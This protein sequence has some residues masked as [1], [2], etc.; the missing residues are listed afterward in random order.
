MYCRNL[1]L[2]LLFA[3]NL[4]AQWN[5]Q[6][7]I[8]EA[9]YD[10]MNN[11]EVI[12]DSLLWYAD[13]IS[14]ASQKIGYKAGTGGAIRLRGLYYQLM[15]NF[16]SAMYYYME[17]EQFGIRERV[18]ESQAA[19]LS[20]QY[21]IHLAL[22]QYDE[23]RKKAFQAVDI[24][25]QNGFQRMVAVNYNN[26]GICWRRQKRYDSAIYYYTK[27]L[28]IRRQMND[29]AGIISAYS[30]IGGL[31]L[32]KHRYNEASG[33][34]YPVLDYHKRMKDSGWLWND[35]STLALMY[36]QWKDFPAALAYL[37]T[38][39][40]IA[41]NAQ[42]KMN[43]AETYKTL[44]E[45]LYAKGDWKQAYD[46][47]LLGTSM[48]SELVNSE[49]A[50]RLLE[51]EQKYKSA[52][53]EQQNKL[54]SAEV[55]Q[56]KLQ[57][58]I[59]LLAAGAVAAV[60][61]LAGV[62]WFQNR[63]K[64]ALL[65]QQNARISEQNM[66]LS[67]LNADKNQLISMVS[68]DL[69]QPLQTI[70]L[71]ADLLEK[72]NNIEAIDHIR[73]SAQYGQQLINHVLDVEKA[74]ANAHT[75]QLQPVPVKALIAAVV[76]D[77]RPAAEGKNIALLFDTSGPDIML[78]TDRQHLQQ[79]LDNLLSNALKFSEP[80]KQ[81]VIYATKQ[82]ATCTITIRDE[83]PGIDADQLKWLFNKYSVAA[84]QPTAGEHSTG[85]GLSIVKRLMLELGGRI[86]VDSKPG[87]G[88]SFSLIFH[89]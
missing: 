19:G 6:D 24:G 16:D 17:L 23:A 22:K 18:P 21:E 15:A 2:C 44:G 35:Y 67:E 46:N 68:H 12:T 72:H 56:Q 40:L 29:S 59:T 47:L 50:D 43:E 20:S 83:G 62:A 10:V 41:V 8:D 55:N 84:P 1:L 52:K 58:R 31:L 76:E 78:T 61:L 60:A 51:L 34:L 73:R 45:V 80:G 63:K 65:Q 36:S 74:G 5:N 71:W 49:T 69:G 85:L 79:V 13:A 11:A 86:E 3:G 87:T 77:F 39:K 33:Y 28:D 89:T 25:K 30:N 88:S 37:D 54:L 26:V 32:Y 57:N 9:M 7:A 53:K 70:S 14:A 4:S 27:A 82:P 81:V 38:A 66:R 48:E 75:I 42:Q 64:N